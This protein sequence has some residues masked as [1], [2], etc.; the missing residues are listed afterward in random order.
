[1]CMC[2]ILAMKLYTIHTNRKYR[3][4]KALMLK[5]LNYLTLHYYMNRKTQEFFFNT[6]YSIQTSKLAQ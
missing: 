2:A 4:S 6:E 1:M 5:Q 3:L